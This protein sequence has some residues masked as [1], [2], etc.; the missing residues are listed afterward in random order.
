MGAM[1]WDD[2]S[3]WENKNSGQYTDGKFGTDLFANKVVEIDFDKQVI[4]VMSNL[5]SS[6]Y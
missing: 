2:V 6:L 4:A 5:Y 1:Q 3:I